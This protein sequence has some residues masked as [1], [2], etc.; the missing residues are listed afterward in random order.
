[1]QPHLFTLEQSELT[2]I[3][4]EFKIAIDGLHSDATVMQMDI[5]Q[6]EKRKLNRSCLLERVATNANKTYNQYGASG[7]N[8]W[9]AYFYEVAKSLGFRF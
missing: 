2:I 1:M 6:T 4:N 5:T 9:F 3:Q 7:F 8:E